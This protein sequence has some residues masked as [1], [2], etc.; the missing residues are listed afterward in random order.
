MAL[1][2]D[3]GP[4]FLLWGYFPQFYNVIFQKFSILYCIL[5]QGAEEYTSDLKLHYLFSSLREM[6]K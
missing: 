6:T 4:T 3:K 1:R 2:Q 5:L